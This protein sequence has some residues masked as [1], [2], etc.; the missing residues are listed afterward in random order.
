MS[1]TIVRR[2]AVVAAAVLASATL[3]AAC[4]GR[5]DTGNTGNVT[6]ADTAAY[7]TVVKQSDCTGYQASPG[8]TPTEIK[9]GSSYP[10][11][12]PLANIGDAARGMAAYFDY[13]NAHGGINGRKIVFI[14]KDDQYDPT[15]TVA[16]VNELLQQDQVFAL[17]GIQSEAGTTSVWTQLAKQCVPILMSTVSGTTMA[18]RLKHL[19]TTDGLV[20]WVDEGYALGQYAANTWKSKGVGLI[21]MAGG[22]Q[23]A[24]TTGVTKG[25]AGTGTKLAD[26]E[27][28]Q[29]TDPTVTSEVTNLK[30]KGVDTVVIAGSG[31]KCPQ[32]L[33]AIHDAGWTPHI[34]ESFTCSSGTLMGLAK[35]ASTEGVVSDTWMRLRVK[36][37]PV[38]DTYFD[39]IAKY[40]PKGNPISEDT[41]VGWTQGQLIAEILKSA[42][43][44]TR[45]SVINR[46][47]SLKNV[48]V[49]MA[50]P[51][52]TYNTSGADPVPY[53]A[54]QMT[55]FDSATKS[56]QYINGTQ[57]LPSGQSKIISLKG[58]LASAG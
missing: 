25:L 35:P 43:D 47:L 9:L 24:F 36:G 41:A 45:L 10:D 28:Y 23:D 53:Q 27:S 2:R 48:T 54:V 1:V 14:G 19:N 49:P 55:R 56:W 26:V 11:S 29:V 39:A 12:G 21:A 6:N 57:V 17:A 44:L 16:N 38:S 8:I 51:G 30:A 5:G 32:I 52:I 4:S 3:L 58:I 31:T 18:D 46:A 50:A 20:P 42:T 22:L 13:V 34:I 7:P 15:K 37:D 33:D 40:D